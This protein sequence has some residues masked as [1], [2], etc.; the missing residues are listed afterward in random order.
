MV[1]VNSVFQSI[2]G[3]V[4]NAGIGS[5]T[6]FVRLAGCNLRCNYCDT[7]YAQQDADGKEMYVDRLTSDIIAMGSRRVT[8]TGGEPLL[9]IKP[10]YRLVNKLTMASIDVSIETNGSIKIPYEWPCSFV[11]DYKLPSSG[12]AEKMALDN[13]DSLN[14][15]DFIKYVIADKADYDYAK[16]I[17]SQFRDE[18]I[19]SYTRRAF[20]PVSGELD[21]RELLEWLIND[22]FT[23]SYLNIQLHKLVKVR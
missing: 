9:Q 15:S 23:D 20:S 14:Y 17:E 22:G 10:V 8:I 3:E 6:T 19:A 21:P 2:N 4:N 7:L 12:M 1:N 13:F 18:Q 16:D 11:V 5:I